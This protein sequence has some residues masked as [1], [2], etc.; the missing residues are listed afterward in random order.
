MEPLGGCYLEATYLLKL[1]CNAFSGR[2]ASHTDCLTITDNKIGGTSKTCFATIVASAYGG[3]STA[4]CKHYVTSNNVHMLYKPLQD[5][6]TEEESNLENAKWAVVD[7]FSVEESNPLWNKTIHRITGRG[8]IT[9][10]RKYAHV[11]SF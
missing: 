10:H 1:F 4:D 5:H 7:D 8:L 2:C 9:A 3:V 11:R 6:I